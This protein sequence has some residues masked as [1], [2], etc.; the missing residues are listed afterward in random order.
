M[1]SRKCAPYGSW[2]SPLSAAFLATGGVRLEHTRSWGED[3]YWLEG[4]PSEAG[5]GV[6]VQ[7]RASGETRDVTPQGFNART[8]VHEYGGCPYAVDGTTVFF[9]NFAD[10]RIYRQDDAGTPLAITPEPEQPCALRYADF[11][12]SSDGRDLYCVRE[13]HA[14]GS[15]ARN[16]L[17]ILA[18]DGRGEPRVLDAA[19]DFVS[20]PRLSPDGRRLAWTSWEHPRM[21][22]DGVDLWVADILLEGRLG[23]P[24]HVAGGEEESIYQPS[25]SPSGEL[26]LISDRSG[27]WNL[28]RAAEQGLEALAPRE[29]E[30]GVPQWIL[31]GG[32]YAFRPDGSLI[33]IWSSAGIDHL[34]VI[35]RPGSELRE[36]Q[37]AFSSFASPAVLPG[38][39]VVLTAASPTE[40]PS[41]VRVDPE[42][43]RITVLKRGRR[44]RPDP[45][46][47]SAPEPIEF[48]TQEGLSAHALFY[49]PVNPGFEA[50]AGESPPLLVVSHGGPTSATSSAL[51]LEIQFWT[52]RGLAVVDVNYGGSTGYGRDYRNRLRG[53]WGVV[54]TADCI[55]AARFLAEAGR[56]DGSRLAIRGGSA[57][58][59]TT[60][61]ALT[62]H[63]VF[64][65]GVSYFGVA[66]AEA[67]ATD[68]HKF[69]SRYLDSLIGPYPEAREL[70][71]ERSP[72]HA[73]HRLSCP[74]LLLQGLEDRVVP[75]S[76]AEVLV[77]ALSERGVPHAYMTFAEE[78]HGFRRAENIIRAQETELYFYGRVFGF[79]PADPIEPIE[80]ANLG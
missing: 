65:A 76:Q 59:Y 57:G 46:F 74:L 75:P 38:G 44:E 54:D 41:V 55:H 13:T 58:G 36:I 52:S 21:P 60:L 3:V 70:Y 25:W 35:D 53:R 34:G 12:L 30:F 27:W 68:T 15:E 64:A 26:H 18:T 31:G 62:F 32:R 24:R 14:P 6:V 37:T 42:S 1:S 7:R 73:A 9:S 69:E 50:P 19:H 28:Y 29:A 10:Q 71:R 56:V 51:K 67:L 77:E 80:I 11:E 78:Q 23:Q 2:E 48:P 8:T 22:W 17:V 20:F 79:T 5:R 33:C 4:R 66:D 16:E 61:C 49:P 72:I 63:D 45:G 40:S 47:I 43:A 39:E